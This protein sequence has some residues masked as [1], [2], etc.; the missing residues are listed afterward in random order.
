[1]TA[2]TP[3]AAPR[4][5]TNFKLRQIT[6]TVSRRYDAAIASTGLKMTQYSLLSHIA[7]M[8]PVRPSD[9]AAK[10][11]LEVSTLSRNL[12]PLIAQGWVDLGPGPD[13]RSRL[14]A[15]TEPGRA[16]RAEVQR[17]WKQAQLQLNDTLGVER[18]AQL[19]QLID[20]CLAVLGADEEGE[21]D[22]E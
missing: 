17:L 11:N 8:E 9:L 7:A 19:H 22:G 2:K 18:V 21:S 15:L 4:G 1:M 6:R 16:K 5:C 10:M 13:A 20:E 14:V 3:T 12:Q